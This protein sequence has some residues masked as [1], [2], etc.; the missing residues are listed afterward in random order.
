MKKPKDFSMF[1]S[2]SEEQKEA[3]DDDLVN[4]RIYKE[5]SHLYIIKES[6]TAKEV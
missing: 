4:R 5:T 6:K 2:T 1:L 3:N